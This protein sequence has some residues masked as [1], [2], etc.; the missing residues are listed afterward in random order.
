MEEKARKLMVRYQHKCPLIKASF[1]GII[2]FLAKDATTEEIVR[3]A[4]WRTWRVKRD[5]G[6][7]VTDGEV[8]SKVLFSFS[9]LAFR[10]ATRDLG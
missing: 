9:V 5:V 4:I 1:H 3:A 2:E 8:E 6:G 10:K 7:V